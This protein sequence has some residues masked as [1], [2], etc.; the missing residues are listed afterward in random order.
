M[1]SSGTT[2]GTTACQSNV[3]SRTKDCQNPDCKNDIRRHRCGSKTFCNSE[4]EFYAERQ[5]QG[6]GIYFLENHSLGSSKNCLFSNYV[7]NACAKPK[8]I[9]GKA[10]L[11]KSKIVH[12]P[13]ILEKHSQGN[14]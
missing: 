1:Y 3:N 10:C 7:K 14:S 6:K 11:L 8:K 12:F 4:F 9:E 2:V 13:Q 5:D